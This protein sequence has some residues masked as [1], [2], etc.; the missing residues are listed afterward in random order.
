MSEDI[1]MKRINIVIQNSK[2]GWVALKLLTFSSV[3]TKNKD[4]T[5]VV[6]QPVLSSVLS[7]I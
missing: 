6:G 5:I 1:S 3:Y 4:T 2:L 7:S